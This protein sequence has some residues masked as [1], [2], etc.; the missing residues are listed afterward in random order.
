MSEEYM[1][2]TWF[3]DAGS[4]FASPENVIDHFAV[5]SLLLIAVE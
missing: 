1:S 5:V 4:G 2:A 3:N